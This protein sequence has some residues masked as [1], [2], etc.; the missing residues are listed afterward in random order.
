MKH[1]N[2]RSSISPDSNVAKSRQELTKRHL[3]YLN[4]IDELATNAPGPTDLIIH[5]LLHVG[6]LEKLHG[7][8]DHLFDPNL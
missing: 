8:S 4:V 1:L 6:F 2:Y 7:I 3:L 5:M